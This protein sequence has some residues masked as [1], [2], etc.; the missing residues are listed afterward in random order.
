MLQNLAIVS[1]DVSTSVHCTIDQSKRM[2]DNGDRLI[3]RG[4]TG[5]ATAL[6]SHHAVE[7]PI[8]QMDQKVSN[9]DGPVWRAGTA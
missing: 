4:L 8:G 6:G 1:H 2:I 9:T 5:D 7:L 3:A